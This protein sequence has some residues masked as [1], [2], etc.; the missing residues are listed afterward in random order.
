MIKNV[1]IRSRTVKNG[2]ERSGTVM[3]TVRNGER[4]STIILYK[5]NGLKRLQNHVHGT[6]TVRSR[7]RFKNERN[8]VLFICAFIKSK[9]KETETNSRFSLTVELDFFNGIIKLIIYFQSKKL[10]SVQIK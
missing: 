1:H 6:V 2:Q 9:T 8:T 5:V 4:Y 3:V 10:K 7:S